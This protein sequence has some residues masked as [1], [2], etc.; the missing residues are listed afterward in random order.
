M[1]KNPNK[2]QKQLPHQ[3]KSNQNKQKTLQKSKYTFNIP[4][5]KKPKH[6]NKLNPA[7][8]SCLNHTKSSKHH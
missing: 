5:K 1:Q 8:K 2:T 7:T 6:E 4:K 3:K